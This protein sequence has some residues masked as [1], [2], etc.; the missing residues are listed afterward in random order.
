[1]RVRWW[2]LRVLLFVLAWSVVG[3][4]PAFAQ[5]CPEGS[6]KIGEEIRDAT[7]YIHC[8][9][10]PGKAPVRGVCI[11]VTPL[12]D[13]DLAVW[14]GRA[15]EMGPALR[16]R[17]VKARGWSARIRA[18]L[19]QA[20]NNAQRGLYQRA[21]QL[22]EG[23]L[24]FIP[25]DEVIKQALER[26]RSLSRAREALGAGGSFFGGTPPV[27]SPEGRSGRVQYLGLAAW[28]HAIAGEYDQALDLLS[29]ALNENPK[30]EDLRQ[31]LMFISRVRANRKLQETLSTSTGTPLDRARNTAKADA[32][33]NLGFHYAENGQGWRAVKYFMEARALYGEPDGKEIVGNL[34]SQVHTIKPDDLLPIYPSKADAIL[35][36]LDYGKGDWQVSL[37]Y[38]RLALQANPH[39]Y[40]IRDAL[41]Y[42]EGLHA[43]LS[44][45][46]K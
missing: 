43:G 46:A 41:N 20:L 27:E 26:S 8:R 19:L 12:S 16:Q 30:D 32:I 4:H 33:M 28:T 31:A 17:L 10:L 23:A 13:L 21:E 35:D 36:A 6:E 5:S 25:T 22:F 7:L 3:V 42:L 45:E 11:D 37:N 9:C 15:F 14:S 39:N 2:Y 29:S 18:R 40:N 34:I 24:K 44:V 1:M 38:L